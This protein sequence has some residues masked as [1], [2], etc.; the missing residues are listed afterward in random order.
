[1]HTILEFIALEPRIEHDL[2]RKKRFSLPTIYDC[3]ALY[4][5][6]KQEKKSSISSHGAVAIVSVAVQS[7]NRP[8]VNAENLTEADNNASVAMHTIESVLKNALSIK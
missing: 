6:L 2:E 4:Q 3:K 8:V 5:S 7:S 1:M